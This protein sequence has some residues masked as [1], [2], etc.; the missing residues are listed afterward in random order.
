MDNKQLVTLTDLHTFKQELLDELK[1]LL[2]TSGKGPDPLWMKSREVRK[3]LNVCPGTLQTMRKKK[4]I[5]F[6]KVGGTIY[7]D[8]SEIHAMFERSKILSK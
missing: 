3:L 8:R 1:A 7:Y 6:H 4:I 2:R 5:V